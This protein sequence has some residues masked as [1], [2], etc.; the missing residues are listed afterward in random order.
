MCKTH[1]GSQGMILNG[2]KQKFFL[3]K[4]LNG[5]RDPSWKKAMKNFHI[6]LTLPQCYV[7]KAHNVISCKKSQPKHSKNQ[8]R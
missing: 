5:T 2:F 8:N 4:K 7:C 3:E 6:F 1:F